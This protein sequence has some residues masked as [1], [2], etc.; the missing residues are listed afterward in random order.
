[1]NYENL[2]EMFGDGIFAVDGDK[3]RHQR[4][5]ASYGFSTKALRDFSSAIFRK[6]ASKLAHVISSYAESNEKFDV[7]V[8]MKSFWF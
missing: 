1:M 3:W 7:Q 8:S 4:K 5:L 2:K 6:N